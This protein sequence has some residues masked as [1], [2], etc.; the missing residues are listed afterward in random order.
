MVQALLVLDFER[1]TK[2]L[3]EAGMQV[4]EQ[5]DIATLLQLVGVSLGGE[6]DKTAMDTLD[7]GQQLGK[8]IG[9]IPVDLILVGCALGLLDGTTKQLDPNP[10]ALEIV[11]SYIPQ[12]Q[13]AAADQSV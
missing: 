12:R 13:E 5:V 2:A 4:D 8:S 6:Q 11:A 7:V 1:L 9:H 3:A 10:D